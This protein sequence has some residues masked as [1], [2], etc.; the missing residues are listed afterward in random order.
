LPT[1][2]V[3]KTHSL[4]EPGASNAHWQS[5]HVT[6]CPGQPAGGG[7]GR[8]VTA[9]PG[10]RVMHSRSCSLAGYPRPGRAAAGRRQPAP[11]AGP[12]VLSLNLS[13]TRRVIT[14]RAGGATGLKSRPK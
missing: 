2:T 7:P 13:H 1:V 14:S 11:W 4:A 5:R 9:W 3:T 12:G 10:I 8:A 6:E